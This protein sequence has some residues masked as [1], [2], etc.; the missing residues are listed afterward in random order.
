[1]QATKEQQYFQ[2]HVD[3]IFYDI[4]RQKA[5]QVNNLFQNQ[6]RLPQFYDTQT[7]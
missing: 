6:C 7:T 5:K 3:I 1:M 2:K 4:Q